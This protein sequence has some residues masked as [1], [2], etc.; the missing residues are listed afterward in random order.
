M[1]PDTHILI[2]IIAKTSSFAFCR[3]YKY[4][5]KFD[6]IIAKL[7]FG[8]IIQNNINGINFN[9]I[10]LKL[11]NLDFDISEDLFLNIFNYFCEPQFNKKFIINDYDE[12]INL[13]TCLDYFGIDNFVQIINVNNSY[14][15]LLCLLKNKHYEYLN[16]FY[17]LLCTN[18]EDIDN[19]II[20]NKIS[21]CYCVLNTYYDLFEY[22]IFIKK[23]IFSDIK[24]V[25]SN[26]H[27]ETD[28]YVNNNFHY[29]TDKYN[30][31]GVNGLILDDENPINYNIM[32]KVTYASLL[33][34]YKITFNSD[35]QNKFEA[36]Y[37]DDESTLVKIPVYNNITNQLFLTTYELALNK[38]F[39]FKK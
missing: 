16:H 9:Y 38:I 22:D 34:K 7:K 26:F 29:E 2:K 37:V 8:I 4:F 27:Y 3:K 14:N 24:Y 6:F 17:K 13:T 11:D 28:K 35:G 33:T 20:N 15:F 1:E 21:K 19:E 39:I 30:I 25:K 10:E 23:N 36:L 5:E 12:F 31:Y 32:F 18:Y